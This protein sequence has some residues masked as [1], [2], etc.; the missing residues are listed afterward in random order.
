VPVL[1]Q[2]LA[3]ATL[4]M[5]QK[6]SIYHTFLEM[7]LCRVMESKMLL[8][9]LAM[10]DLLGKRWCWRGHAVWQQQLTR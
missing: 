8:Y 1:E 7:W 2:H 10:C 5:T 6:G 4:C 3:P 9:L